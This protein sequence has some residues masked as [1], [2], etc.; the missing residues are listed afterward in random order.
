MAI[1]TGTSGNDTL[2]GGA[3]D[4]SINGGDGRDT[5]IGG[6]GNDTLDGGDGTDTA[7]YSAATTSIMIAAGATS[8][9][10]SFS[11]IGDSTLES[12][13][14]VVLTMGTPTGATLG[15]NTSYTHTIT[16]DD[17]L[18][19]VVATNSSVAGAEIKFTFA[20]VTSMV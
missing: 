13:E 14:T 11:V 18:I 3:G 15:A 8:G 19:D 16:N 5:L 17:V 9:T 2:T 20:A 4:D 1:L 7:D 10:A 12:N 6:L